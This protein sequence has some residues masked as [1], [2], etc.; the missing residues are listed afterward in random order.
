MIIRLTT[1]AV[2]AGLAACAEVTPNAPPLAPTSG[3]A[4]VRPAQ[5]EATGI[6]GANSA[7]ASAGAASITGAAGR[8]DGKPSISYSG[9]AGSPRGAGTGVVQDPATVVPRNSSRGN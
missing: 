5:T 3:G 1:L 4:S 8:S 7:N 2:L 9:P 6:A